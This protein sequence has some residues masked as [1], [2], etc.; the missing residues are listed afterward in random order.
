M[1]KSKKYLTLNQFKTIKT[2]QKVSKIASKIYLKVL[3]TFSAKKICKNS[4]YVQ[5]EQKALLLSALHEKHN[6][7]PEPRSFLKRENSNIMKIT[8]ELKT[9]SNCF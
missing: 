5:H 1:A 8:K 2:K 3:R 6:T 4:K 7:R 9:A